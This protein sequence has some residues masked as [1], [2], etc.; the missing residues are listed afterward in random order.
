MDSLEGAENALIL[1]LGPGALWPQPWFSGWVGGAPLPHPALFVAV[2]AQRPEPL[3]LKIEG[4]TLPQ[5]ERIAHL[6]HP[7]LPSA[8]TPPEVALQKRVE[9]LRRKID[10]ALDIYRELQQQ[11]P[12]REDIAVFRKMAQEEITRLSREL[13]ELTSPDQ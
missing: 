12:H 13:K 3:A 8:L 6:I 4:L 11:D 5:R 1:R 2:M 9:E 7:D 10:Q